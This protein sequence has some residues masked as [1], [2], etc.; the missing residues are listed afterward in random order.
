MRILINGLFAALMAL[1]A[2][3]ST[4]GTASS[5][6]EINPYRTPIVTNAQEAV[7]DALKPAPVTVTRTETDDYVI[8][9]MICVP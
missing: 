1:T 3:G 6:R 9:S 8:G 5:F 7:W 4:P 2:S